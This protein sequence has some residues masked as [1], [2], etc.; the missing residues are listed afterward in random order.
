MENLYLKAKKIAEEADVSTPKD[1]LVLYSISFLPTPKNKEDAFDYLSKNSQA[2][3]IDQTPCGKQLIELGMLENSLPQE[4]I[5]EI[6]AI[7]SRRLIAKAQGNITAFVVNA[8]KRS[9]FRSQELPGLLKNPNVK[10]INGIDKNIFAAQ[11][12]N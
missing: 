6:W 8:D 7:A 2:M 10:T 3:M 11:F 9:V 1:C 5:M 12:N 4:Q